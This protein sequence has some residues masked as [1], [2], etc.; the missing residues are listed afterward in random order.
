MTTISTSKTVGIDLSTGTYYQS[1]FYQSWR[2]DLQQH[3]WRIF[4]RLH[5]ALDNPE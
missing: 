3:E 2:H 1:R 4:R 5:R